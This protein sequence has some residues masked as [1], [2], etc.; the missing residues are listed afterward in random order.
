ME[1]IEQVQRDL[2][3]PVVA[4]AADNWIIFLII[5]IIGGWWFYFGTLSRTVVEGEIVLGGEAE[6]SGSDGGGDG[7]GD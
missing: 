6:S 4:F 1:W 3:G 5:A 7:G 2:G